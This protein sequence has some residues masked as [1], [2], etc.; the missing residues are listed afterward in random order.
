MVEYYGAKVPL[1]QVAAVSVTDSTL[2]SVNVFDASAVSHVEKAILT[3]DLNLNP[4]VDGNVV[5]LKLPDLTE[6]R[7]KELV[8]LVK[9][10]GEDAKVILRNIRRDCLDTLKD[11]E[12]N[13]E[14]SEDDLKR[15]T[16]DA[17]KIIE[18]YTKQIDELV[19]KK[20][21][22]ILTV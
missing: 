8:K 6:D 22:D 4:Q 9:K 17:Q 18:N 7:R 10:E 13:K 1:N 2:L 16:D 12:K 19:S 15:Q 5:R 21:A 11:Q 14:I 20:E 3:S